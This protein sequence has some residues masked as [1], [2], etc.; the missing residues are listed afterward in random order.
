M[1][2][3]Y[4]PTFSVPNYA[5]L[6]EQLSS[7][8]QGLAQMQQTAAAA[9]ANELQATLA[10]RAQG[11]QDELDMQRFSL[12][13]AR[14]RR[15]END[16]AARNLLELRKMNLEER[17]RDAKIRESEERARRDALAYEA[18]VRLN[19]KLGQAQAIAASRPMLAAALLDSIGSD[20]GLGAM[21]AQFHQDLFTA[22]AGIEGVT[23]AIN[24]ESYTM[25]QAVGMAKNMKDQDQRARGFAILKQQGVN[26][27]DPWVWGLFGT[28]A[29]DTLSAAINGYE[30]LVETKDPKKAELVVRARGVR[31]KMEASKEYLGL[32]ERQLTPGDWAS[33]GGTPTQAMANFMQARMAQ[34]DLKTEYDATELRL[35][36]NGLT[37][38]DVDGK[39]PGLTIGQKA[40][41]AADGVGARAAV[42]P[43]LP[44]EAAEAAAAELGA[45]AVSDGADEPFNPYDHRHR[46]M[47]GVLTA[48]TATAAL[49]PTKTQAGT[50]GAAPSIPPELL[51]ARSG[52]L[53]KAI[54][55]DD[56]IVAAN[57]ATDVDRL[58]LYGVQIV[59]YYAP[60]GAKQSSL[61]QDEAMAAYAGYLREPPKSRQGQQHMRAIESQLLSSFALVAARP[62]Q[63]PVPAKDVLDEMSPEDKLRRLRQ[64]GAASYAYASRSYSWPLAGRFGVVPG[65]RPK[66]LQGSL[67]NA[68]SLADEVVLRFEHVDPRG[69]AAGFLASDPGAAN[70]IL[71]RTFGV[72]PGGKSV[73]VADAPGVSGKPAA[74]YVAEGSVDM[75]TSTILTSA[76]GLPTVRFAMENYP[77]LSSSSLNLA[78]S[79]RPDWSY[80]VD[81]ETWGHF[82]IAPVA[83][84]S[85]TAAEAV[86]DAASQRDPGLASARLVFAARIYDRLESLARTHGVPDPT[87]APYAPEALS[88]PER[89]RVEVLRGY[90]N[91][92]NSGLS[93]ALGTRREL[94]KL[95]L[96]RMLDGV[97]PSLGYSESDVRAANEAKAALAAGLIPAGLA[98]AATA[99]GGPPAPAAA[100]PAVDVKTGG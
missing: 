22:R 90:V 34:T 50:S 37:W 30:R 64:L 100:L 23:A 62:G 98:P 12:E 45:V 76:T 71:S 88:P 72:D 65:L 82:G 58:N 52:N 86:V 97:D 79:V 89:S 2:T 59:R 28:E 35:S 14:E 60:V 56:E 1:A 66:Q 15:Q 69:A 11:R 6:G 36:A 85:A 46:K 47:V 74:S 51:V 57:R 38:D 68:E 17:E 7:G 10:L 93:K 42:D 78:L 20:P 67:E 21:P 44:P 77:G 29:P 9:R 92:P 4:A 39:P 31:E 41:E 80:R 5:D 16:A 94:V 18:G 73:P 96:D 26:I 8:L 27:H 33:L 49:A 32:L 84:G 54:A 25:E 81:T 70:W 83:A 3:R 95:A 63:P 53:A 55:S 40:K 61:S 87:A 75:A 43:A 99:P 48:A 19:P 24:A 91:D 13:V